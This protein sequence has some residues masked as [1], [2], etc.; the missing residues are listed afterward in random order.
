MMGAGLT[1]VTVAAAGWEQAA[2]G[3]SEIPKGKS[4]AKIWLNPAVRLARLCVPCVW[5]SFL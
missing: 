3:F 4:A 1:R 2:A 5:F